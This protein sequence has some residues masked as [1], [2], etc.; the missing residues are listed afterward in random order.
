MLG[1]LGVDV[2]SRVSLMISLY[3]HSTVIQLSRRITY[4]G[5]LGSSDVIDSCVNLLELVTPQFLIL[6]IMGWEY[7]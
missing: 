7:Y 1:D 2:S 6:G 3:D 5:D 4:G